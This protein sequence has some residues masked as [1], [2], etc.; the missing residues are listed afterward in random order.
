M[1]GPT[2]VRRVRGLGRHHQSEWCRPELCWT[3]APAALTPALP[4]FSRSPTYGK[5]APA[6]NIPALRNAPS[7]PIRPSPTYQIALI[8]SATPD[9]L[10]LGASKGATDERL[11]GAESLK[12]EDWPFSEPVFITLYRS[13]TRW[14][15]WPLLTLFHDYQDDNYCH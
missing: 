5:S 3:N 1:A 7:R 8:P 2:G 12:L 6:A 4:N 9:G 14:A 11:F 15:L 13:R 10:S